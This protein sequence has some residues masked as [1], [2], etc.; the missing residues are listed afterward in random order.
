MEDEQKL[1]A[2][3]GDVRKA[4][5][6]ELERFVDGYRTALREGDVEYQLVD[7]SQPPAEVLVRFL[8]GPYR[9]RGQ[10]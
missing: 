7:T 5:L 2:D 4:Y 6:A 3:P 8:T 9:T 1:L 10:R